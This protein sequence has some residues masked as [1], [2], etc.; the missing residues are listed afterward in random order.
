MFSVPLNPK[1]DVK[2]LDE[3]VD[4]LNECKEVIY[5][6]YFTCR[7][8]PFTQ[9]AMGD[10]FL[11]GEEDHDYL[12]NLALEIQEFTGITASAVF[13]NIYVRPTQD[14]FDLFIETFKP[15]YDAGI[16]SATIPHTHWVATGQIQAAFPELFIKNT[17]LRNV[18]EPRDIEKLAKAGFNYIN[19]DRDLMRD[20]EKLLRF[21]KAKEKYGVKLSLLANEGCMGGC[22]MMDEH[23]HF[24]N[25]RGNGPQYFTDPISRVSCMK[26]D[27]EDQA[28]PLKTANFPPWKEDW[29]QFLNELGIDVIKMHGRESTSR[30]RETMQII[31]NYVNNKEILF[32]HFKDFIEETNMADKPI[33]IW[34]KKIKTC[35]FDCWDCGYCDKIMAAK[36]GDKRQPRTMVVTRELVD[37]VHR[38]L[39]INIPGLTSSRIQKL[40]NGLASQSK[41]YLEIGAYLGAT[42]AAALANNKLEAYVVDL[43]E[44]DLQP[45]R[46]DLTLPPNSQAEFEKNI[47][48]YIGENKVHIINEDMY[49]V[50]TSEISEVDLFFYDGPH[51]YEHIYKTVI[52]YRNCFAK[53]AILVF[54]DAN[55]TDTVMAAN[56]AV[57][58]GGLTPIYSKKILN[59]IES[60]KDWWNGIYIIVIAS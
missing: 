53:Q 6:F 24:N 23:Y 60:E 20:H 2:S 45:V 17:I 56:Q 42:T 51:E 32:Q 49:E 44:Q 27:Y 43:W 1:L 47:A 31:R 46:D 10:V 25:E 7:I 14:N 57:K 48:P 55:W 5:D 37:S 21:K 39:D 33:D 15:L 54:D 50:D 26:W 41:V 40:L 13:N 9:D 36:Y 18:S 12:N 38:E 28:V 58:D 19:L 16:R 35:K 8:A 22:I 4:F 30:L 52:R 11:E 3:F 59:S 34:R 29:D